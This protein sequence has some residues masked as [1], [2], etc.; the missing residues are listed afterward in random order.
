MRTA[1]VILHY[2]RSAD[3]I[4]SLRRMRALRDRHQFV[5]VDNASSAD[6]L[7]RMRNSPEM[8]GVLLV[9]MAHNVGSCAWDFG[10]AAADAEI[11]I[12]LD[13]DSH[14]E[15]ASVDV[16]GRR[17]EAE[18]DLGAV[19]LA[20]TGGPFPCP[21]RPSYRRGT[22]VGFIGCGVAFRK[23]AL[24][25]AGGHDP[26]FFIYADEWDLSVRLLA[27]GFEIDREG[28]V[29]VTHR[30]AQMSARTSPR[31]IV[32]TTR[33]ETLMARKYFRRTRFFRLLA[34]VLVWNCTR[35]WGAGGFAPLYVLQGLLLGL[36][37]RRVQP[38]PIAD[39]V[40][41]LARYEAWMGAFRPLHRYWR[42][43]SR[44]ASTTSG[45]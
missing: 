38:V 36:L 43:W 32:H 33:N 30:T 13:D 14:I 9:P 6:H 26:N 12:K 37:D 11:V 19:P 25:R 34:R 5:V 17:F 3:L 23:E 1:I 45:H 28:S 42:P 21:D 18:P 24:V 31:L 44:G 20:V 2:N 29:A 39:P 16:L 27:A 4:E 15:S 10:A 40:S 41:L 7:E 8:D 22:S 35:F